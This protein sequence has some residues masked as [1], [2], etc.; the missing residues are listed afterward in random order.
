MFEVAAGAIGLD[1]CIGAFAGAILIGMRDDENTRSL[2]FWLEFPESGARL[3]SVRC[4]YSDGAE[5]PD[6]DLLRATRPVLIVSA[7][8]QEWDDL[9]GGNER[10]FLDAVLSGKV[11]ISGNFPRYRQYLEWF[12]AAGPRLQLPTNIDAFRAGRG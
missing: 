1:D 2:W 7:T 12:L 9:H 10:R 8:Q 4:F 3:T 5:F 11:E 6:R